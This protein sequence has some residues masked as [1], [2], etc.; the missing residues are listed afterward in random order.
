MKTKKSASSITNTR[1]ITQRPVIPESFAPA[2]AVSSPMPILRA[3]Q[4]PPH[5][6]DL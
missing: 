5:L 1:K 6:G 3:V 2:N 4:A